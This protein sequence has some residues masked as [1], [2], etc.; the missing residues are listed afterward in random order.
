MTPAIWPREAAE[1][2]M[3]HVDPRSRSIR[4]QRVSELPALLR[5]GDLVVVNDAATLPASLPGSTA[6]GA[7][8]VRLAAAGASAR[9]WTAVLFG[10]GSWR[11]RTEDRPPPPRVE[12]GDVIAFDGLLADVE[13]VSQLSPRLLDVRFRIPKRREPAAGLEA[14]ESDLWTALYRA[15]RPVQYSY[16][17]GPLPLWH[18]QTAFASRPWSVEMPSAGRPLRMPLL[19]QLRTRGVQV[20]ALTHAAGLSSTGDPAID[21]ALPLPERYEIPA[22]TAAAIERA[23]RAG[24]RLI[25]V[26]TTVVRALEGNADANG[27]A[28]RPGNGISAL[29]I[30][31]AFRPRVVDALLTGVHEPGTSHY[32]LVSA[33]VPRDLL[34][35]ATRH[36]ETE[37][38]LAHEFGDSLLA[39]AA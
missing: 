30:G 29:R 22:S 3:L 27:G 17:C 7:V 18:V 15:A 4:D 37:S 2:R 16:L 21:A 38:Y 10:S 35:A 33:F 11:Q 20:A 9:E 31:A 1:T 14:T 28:L 23:R 24:G 5:G 25:A 26:G 39:L 19:R 34:E 12:V 13:R 6:G 32:D 36:A 8:E